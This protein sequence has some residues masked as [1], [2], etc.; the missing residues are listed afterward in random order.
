MARDYYRMHSRFSASS[1]EMCTISDL[2]FGNGWIYGANK[3]FIAGMSLG[4]SLGDFFI[5]SLH[6]FLLG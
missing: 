6:S 3:T 5:D 1:R 2:S 4:A